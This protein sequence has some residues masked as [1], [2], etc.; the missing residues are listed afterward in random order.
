[1]LRDSLSIPT[2]VDSTSGPRSGRAA[3]VLLALLSVGI[4]FGL[5]FG[6]GEPKRAVDPGG[7]AAR[8]E[9]A[10][11]PGESTSQESISRER[12]IQDVAAAAVP[13][14]VPAGAAAAG[15]ERVAQATGP[16]EDAAA[17]RF[18]DAI[19]VRGTVRSS[20][21]GALLEGVRVELSTPP[22]F[23]RQLAGRTETDVDGGFRLR[24]GASTPGDLV[25]T[26]PRFVDARS[27]EIDM[28]AH[29][30]LELVPSARLEGQVLGA[31]AALSEGAPAFVQAW[32]SKTSARRLW[33]PVETELVAP[34]IF[35][36]EDLVPG[37]YLVTA[38]VPGRVVPVEAGLQL[39]PGEEQTLLLEALEGSRLSVRLTELPPSKGLPGTPVEGAALL[40]QAREQGL[41]EQALA[42]RSAEARSDEAGQAWF[43]GL[44]PGTYR[45]LVTLPWG[46]RMGSDVVIES[47]GSE[48]ELELRC[49]RAASLAGR[50][51]DATGRPVSGARL[52]VY[53]EGDR[54]RR[55]QLA[56]WTFGAEV[57]QVRTDG[58]GGFRFEAV[59]AREVLS[60][61]VR[62]VDE[63]PNSG[64]RVLSPLALRVPALAPGSARADVELVLPE[65][66]TLSL[67]LRD[68]EGLAPGGI[69]EVYRAEVE[70]GTRLSRHEIHADAPLRIGG[71][72]RKRLVV[73]VQ[74]EG[75]LSQRTTVD[76]RG[77]ELELE[78]TL[79]EALE[80]RGIALDEQGLGIPGLPVRLTLE[81]ETPL[82]ESDLQRVRKHGA[83]TDETGRFVFSNL[84]DVPWVV[85]GGS[86]EWELVGA[87]PPTLLPSVDA[88]TT[89]TFRPRERPER[90]SIRGRVE[91]AG[92]VAPSGLRIEGLRG[93]ILDLDGGRFVASGLTPTR[94]RLTL[95]GDGHRR[96][97][98]GPIDP[99]PGGVVD[100]GLL[101]LELAGSVTV[102]VQDPKGRPLKDA[103]AFL[104]PLPIAEGGPADER[105]IPLSGD[106]KA[107]FRTSEAARARYRLVVRAKGFKTETRE[108]D[109]G[110]TPQR[111]L[112]VRL[113]KEG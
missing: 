90:F 52:A 83:V 35:A 104:R 105:R 74:S 112:R 94:H 65:E 60:V 97:V 32:R 38:R 7:E 11:R 53:E 92:G 108:L 54:Q 4:V 33:E 12:S 10:V 46:E 72:P 61:A 101:S 82:D 70:R 45:L 111:G 56:E 20:K 75:Y 37:E 2:S 42:E 103:T 64:Q 80:L 85:G 88:W 29:H 3:L 21:G 6:L 44:A 58:S 18:D 102:R 50:V 63:S 9:S 62:R 106:D 78:L 84:Y 15:A 39:D 91:G 107:R 22:E 55:G 110:E 89:L 5:L 17:A 96:L 30:D 27:P 16:L 99:R 73:F 8:V 14:L 28:E 95:R 59:P 51:L 19:E 43:E 48:Q 98:V 109:L 25:L 47:S 36:F 41:P 1:M 71:L 67:T 13:A 68:E 93:G 100:L 66:A 34:G 24:W 86:Y 87:D 76:L 26:H 77:G 49:R 40:L 79:R 23:Q 31:S 57:P 69:V 113:Q 81:P